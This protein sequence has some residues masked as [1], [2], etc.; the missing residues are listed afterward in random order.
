MSHLA[1][2]INQVE[3]PTNVKDDAEISPLADEIDQSE[4]LTSLSENQ[5]FP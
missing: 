1:D 4:S 3:S 5:N 2:E